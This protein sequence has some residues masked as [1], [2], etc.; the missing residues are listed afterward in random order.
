MTPRQDP[1]KSA[2][3]NPKEFRRSRGAERFDAGPALSWRHVTVVIAAVAVGWTLY[4]WP[5]SGNSPSVGTRTLPPSGPLDIRYAEAPGKPLAPLKLTGS[6]HG[7]HCLLR[8]S[9]WQTGTPVL[10]IFIRSGESAETQIPIGQY[11]ATVACGTA[12][13]GTQLLGRGADVDE[14]E[15]PIVFSQSQSGQ[16]HGVQIDLTK[17]V[18]GNLRTRSVFRW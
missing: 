11:R 12:W 13:H 10:A 6:R 7:E 4:L 16:T 18:G 9:K 2:V 8:L 5:A 14:F 3:Y 15:L 1:V 17:R